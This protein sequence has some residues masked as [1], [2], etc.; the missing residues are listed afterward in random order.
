MQG[1][2]DDLISKISIAL[3]IYSLVITA[4]SI[5]S[6]TYYFADGGNFFLHMMGTG[7]FVLLNPNRTHAH[8]VTQFLPV[9]AMK[10]FGIKNYALLSYLYGINLYLPLIAGLVIC[11][12]L[13]RNTNPY[14]MLF[15]LL[16][17]FGVSMNGMMHTV[18]QGH[19]ISS[20][21]WA[22]I[23]YMTQKEK[24]SLKDSIIFFVLVLVFMKSYE[25]ALFLGPVLALVSF[26]RIFRRDGS[27][28][29]L[30]AAATVC[31]VASVI[32]ALRE[33]L[34]PF[35][36]GNKQNFIMSVF[37]LY[38]HYPAVL[39]MCFILVIVS[40]LL[41]PTLLK[42][43]FSFI[44]QFLLGLALLVAFSP[45]AVPGLIKPSL[46][47]NAR[48]L[49]AYVVPPMGFLFYLITA[50][51]ISVSED[52]WKRVG[53]LTAILIFG[54]ISWQMIA[55][56]Q[57]K[58]FRHVFKTELSQ[59]R[60]LLLFEDSILSRISIGNQLISPFVIGWTVPT[61]SILWADSGNVSTIITANQDFTT[62]QPFDPAKIDELPK[63]EQFG[64]SYKTYLESP[65]EIEG[66]Y[67]LGAI[68]IFSATGNYRRYVQNGWSFAESNHV[69]TSGKNAS[70]SFKTAQPGSD[71]TIEIEMSPFLAPP[72]VTR[73]R[74]TLFVNGE[75]VGRPEIAAPGKVQLKVPRDL[76]MKKTPAIVEFILPDAVSPS[77]IGYNNDT[78]MLALAFKSLTIH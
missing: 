49:M 57:W 52:T 7:D 30:W 54:Q 62:W 43:H 72:R 10:I 34:H 77:S 48:V 36:P 58:G 11:Y 78:R 60:G 18:G 5:Y 63:I 71:P 4:Y 9:A 33:I 2:N 65:H 53:I 20:F 76:W 42:K 8:Y 56:S 15:P 31:F 68:V 24:Y 51:R 13:V 39:S 55:V 32:I 26:P 44:Q 46:Q 70:L 64:F 12:L 50:G 69:W 3:G 74:L 19:V 27:Q 61:M 29:L 37:G 17:L 45:L 47:Y 25:S 6:Q 40:F 59:H 1:R 16:S 14:L 22:I 67:T 38:Q 35:D 23:F 41:M 28:K 75:E 73:Q 66:T 21:F